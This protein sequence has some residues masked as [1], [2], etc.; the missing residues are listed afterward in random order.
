MAEKQQHLGKGQEQGRRLTLGEAAQE[1]VG[2]IAKMALEETL[3]KGKMI[4]I[5]SLGV[6]ITPDRELK[7][8]SELTDDELKANPHVHD[9]LR[10]S[11]D[12][13]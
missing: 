10:S 13:A 4:H 12:N 11:S 1:F 9:P 2:G 7:N 6:V 8:V 3:A 5:P